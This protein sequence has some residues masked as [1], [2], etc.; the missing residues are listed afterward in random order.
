MNPIKFQVEGVLAKS[1]SQPTP[2]T[3][4]IQIRPN[5]RFH[6]G[7]VLNADDVVFSL[8]RAR[9][10]ES[11]FKVY[12]NNVARIEKVSPMLIQIETKKADPN[13]LR[14]LILVRIMSKN[15]AEKNQATTPI[16]ATQ[17]SDLQKANAALPVG[18][19]PFIM[20]RWSNGTRM[21][22]RR[23]PQWW[24][25]F[26]GNLSKIIYEAEPDAPKR[27][28]GLI[29]GRYQLVL[30]PPLDS[31]SKLRASSGVSVQLTPEE[32]AMFIGINVS[33]PTIVRPSD[34]GQNPSQANPFLKLAVRQALYYATDYAFLERN[35]MAR[36]IKP[37]ALPVPP[38]AF[39]WS[40][41]WNQRLP[42]NPAKARQLLRQAGY[43][44]GFDVELAC[45]DKRF[46]NEA[47]V[48][49]ALAAMWAKVGIRAKPVFYSSP[50]HYKKLHQ[51]DNISLY[52][53]GW[54]TATWDSL[55]TLS[56]LFK[57][58]RADDKGSYNA[59]NYSNAELDKIIDALAGVHEPKARLA[60]MNKSWEILARDLPIVP[61]Y[62]QSSPRAF[63]RGSFVYSSSHALIM[64]ENVRNAKP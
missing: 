49:R 51:R 25:T 3:W 64:W 59:G 40:A 43:A 58:N 63:Q 26:K 21:E 19:G 33:S 9:L 8:E 20:E 61:L 55:Y 5:V 30:D 35:V 14:Y 41:Q 17:T 47:A 23:N 27:V 2:T 46:V 57:T 11:G 7:S 54:A 44:Q 56:R 12:F 60:L 16:L 13:F 34:G 15:W 53:L 6:D 42:Y 62:Y 48:C 38:S 32:R 36:T 24:G 52:Y 10:P 29:A 50:D 22:F 37:T 1:W 31:L 28:S 39:G 4:L 18:T 45:S